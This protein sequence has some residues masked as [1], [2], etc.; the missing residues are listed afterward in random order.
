MVSS[1]LAVTEKSK[2][3][4]FLK[5]QAARLEPRLKLTNWTNCGNNC[6][7][8]LDVTIAHHM[9][10]VSSRD[11]RTSR[12]QV[13]LHAVKTHPRVET[14]PVKE[15]PP[16]NQDHILW[17]LSRS[18]FALDRLLFSHYLWLRHQ[19]CAFGRKVSALPIVLGRTLVSICGLILVLVR[20]IVVVLF[21]LPVGMRP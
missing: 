7:R 11:V 8:W 16:I 20:G 9:V 13:S 21:I 2:L 14:L 1:K 6:C 17:R 4:N 3:E 18:P 5:K 19:P 10:T 12:Y 15:R